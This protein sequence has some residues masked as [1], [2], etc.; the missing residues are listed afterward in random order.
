M[1]CDHPQITNIQSGLV[2]VLK[3]CKVNVTYQ[4]FKVSKNLEKNVQ[5]KHFKNKTFKVVKIFYKT[6]K[7]SELKVKHSK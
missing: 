5:S 2:D 1:Q 3:T 6:L 4:T 7:V